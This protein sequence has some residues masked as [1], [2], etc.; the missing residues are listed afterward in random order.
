[1]EFYELHLFSFKSEHLTLPI[2]Q[3]KM[4]YFFYRESFFPK[5]NLKVLFLISNLLILMCFYL[6]LFPP[7]S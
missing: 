2:W 3:L 6:F 4:Q 5:F 1:M 7:Y